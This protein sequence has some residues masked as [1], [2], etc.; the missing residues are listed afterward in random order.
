MIGM[1]N[2][3]VNKSIVLYDSIHSSVKKEIP[4]AIKQIFPNNR[5]T[6][7]VSHCCIQNIANIIKS[8]NNRLVNAKRKIH[9]EFH[10]ATI[11]RRSSAH[12]MAN[13]F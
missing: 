1:L 5:S 3:E 4:Q 7:K 10:Y 2:Q 9:K 6:V 11:K 12:W 13:I 8:R